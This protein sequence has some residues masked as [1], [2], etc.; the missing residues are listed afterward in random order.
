MYMGEAVLMHVKT[1]EGLSPKPHCSLSNL[2]WANVEDFW[3]LPQTLR[4]FILRLVPPFLGEIHGLKSPVL[5]LYISLKQN[6]QT[7]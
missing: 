6:H 1:L 5:A 2:W 3:P 7:S 4:S